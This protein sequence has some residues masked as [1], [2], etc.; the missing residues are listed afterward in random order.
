MANLKHIK[1]KIIEVVK[2]HKVLWNQ[3]SA[4]YKGLSQREKDEV[5][6]GISKNLGMTGKYFSF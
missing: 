4:L 6:A 5:W 3:G 1:L 2:D